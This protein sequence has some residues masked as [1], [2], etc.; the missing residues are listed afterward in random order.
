[1]KEHLTVPSFDLMTYSPHL[2]AGFLFA[3]QFIPAFDRRKPPLTGR[4][5]H[6][7]FPCER[8]TEPAV[9]GSAVISAR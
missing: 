4:G 7:G 6:A 9:A 1:M 5:L 8:K 2:R 3:V